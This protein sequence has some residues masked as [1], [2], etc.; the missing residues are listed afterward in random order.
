MHAPL[1]YP[2]QVSL[3]CAATTWHP[4]LM[5][6]RGNMAISSCMGEQDEAG[7]PLGRA[8]TLVR[9]ALSAPRELPICRDEQRNLIERRWPSSFIHH[10]DI[11]ILPLDHTLTFL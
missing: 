11:A 10:S 6:P 5:I 9:A 2:A 4:D 8:S 1:L 3:L 7:Y